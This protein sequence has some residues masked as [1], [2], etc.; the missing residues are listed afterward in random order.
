MSQTERER[1]CALLYCHEL[2][3]DVLTPDELT[4]RLATCSLP[5]LRAWAEAAGL[6][7]VAHTPTPPH[8]HTERSDP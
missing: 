6:G 3:A 5:R 2:M 7:P 1:L 8:S 4:E